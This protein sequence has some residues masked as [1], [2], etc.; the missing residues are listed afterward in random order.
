MATR[1]YEERRE[2]LRIATEATATLRTYQGDILD[3]QMVD[4]SA[5]GAMLTIEDDIARGEEVTFLSR[6]V[7]VVATVAWVTPGNCGLSFHRR[8]QLGE[9]AL[10]TRKGRRSLVTNG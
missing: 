9:V 2:T 5:G 1:P 7:E 3:A 6:G 10:L 8:L 4:V